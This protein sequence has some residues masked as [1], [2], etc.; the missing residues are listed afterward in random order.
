M[1]IPWVLTLAG[2]GFPETFPRV[3]GAASALAGCSAVVAPSREALRLVETLPAAVERR[4][5][6]CGVEARPLAPSANLSVLGIGRQDRAHGFD[7]LLRAFPGIHRSCPASELILAGDGPLHRKLVAMA[8]G[9]PP[10][11]QQSITW[12]E[13]T[14]LEKARK[15]HERA[16]VIA[17]PDRAAGSEGAIAQ[18]LAS[19]RAL[20]VTEASGIPVHAIDGGNA[21][22]VP[23]DDAASLGEAIASLLSDPPS[24][25]RLGEAAQ[26]EALRH[27]SW[28][29][30]GGEY[31]ELF[32]HVTAKK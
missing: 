25:Q 29:E 22:V 14:S 31:M 20:V 9:F 17:F 28:L 11:V 32:R 27:L 15:L 2:G 1:R 12:E 16:R 10:Q 21:R 4:I 7:T 23:P 13:V 6:P 19:G 5:I 30:V 3:P 24:A 8:R 26:G 18:A